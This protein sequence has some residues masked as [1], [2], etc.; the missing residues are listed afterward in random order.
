MSQITLVTEMHIIVHPSHPACW[1][2]LPCLTNSYLE[3]ADFVTRINHKIAPSFR[4]NKIPRAVVRWLCLAT[5]GV[6]CA[7]LYYFVSF[8]IS[9]LETVK[10]NNLYA[11]FDGGN[12]GK[13]WIVY[14]GCFAT[15]VSP[16]LIL[17]KFSTHLHFHWPYSFMCSIRTSCK[18]CEKI[19]IPCG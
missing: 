12:F 10:F 9:S 7:A 18:Y 16:S 15:P 19:L 13:A 6:L 5:I 11:S 14:L 8:F 17:L 3:S 1:R 2:L 4:S